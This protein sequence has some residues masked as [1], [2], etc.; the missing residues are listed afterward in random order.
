MFESNIHCQYSFSNGSGL[1]TDTLFGLVKV[2]DNTVVTQDSVAMGFD[3]GA[4]PEPRVCICECV[5]WGELH[6]GMTMLFLDNK[7]FHIFLA[8]YP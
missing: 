6:G 4:P 7:K 5:W 8:S 1:V 3:C 2:P